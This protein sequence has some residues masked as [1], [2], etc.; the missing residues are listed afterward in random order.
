[1]TRQRAEDAI[2]AAFDDGIK[3]LFGVLVLNLTADAGHEEAVKR[4]A[5]GVGILDEAHAKASEAVER[6]FPE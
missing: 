1:M 4:F 5:S 3:R 2:D 6:I